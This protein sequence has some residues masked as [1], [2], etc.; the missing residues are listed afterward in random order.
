M[1]DYF[2]A[3]FKNILNK[4]IKG[5]DKGNGCDKMELEVREVRKY[6]NNFIDRLGDWWWIIA[7]GFIS[8]V[9]GIVLSLK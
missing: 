5:I 1:L 6:S 3:L 9:L 7:I 2:L 4:L 8:W